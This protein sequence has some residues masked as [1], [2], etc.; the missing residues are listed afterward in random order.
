MLAATI[1]MATLG[2]QGMRELALQNRARAEYAKAALAKIPGCRLPY[3]GPSFNEFVL[4]I[5]RESTGVHRHLLGKGIVA[6]LRLARYYPDRKNDLLITV[7]ETNSRA[8]ID[9]FAK[10][11]RGA[12]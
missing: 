6:G 4:E 2:K 9:R 10:E 7:T 3:P 8:Q 12:L 11:L 1:F 5:P